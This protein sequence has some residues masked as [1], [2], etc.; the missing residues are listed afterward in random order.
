MRTTCLFRQRVQRHWI[1][2]NERTGRETARAA[3]GEEYP[4][5]RSWRLPSVSRR[6]AVAHERAAERCA[7][8]SA[9]QK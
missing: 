6:L 3:E 1:R 4:P 5:V 8:E 9:E 2:A 7:L